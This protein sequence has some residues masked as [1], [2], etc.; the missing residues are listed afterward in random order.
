MFV[1]ILKGTLL[2]YSHCSQGAEVAT[3][4]LK[5]HR[6]DCTETHGGTSGVLHDFRLN[7]F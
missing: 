2:P 1:N 4:E 7:D 3:G 5:V 6:L